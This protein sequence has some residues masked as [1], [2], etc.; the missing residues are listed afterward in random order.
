MRYDMETTLTPKQDEAWEYLHDDTSTE[1]FLWWWAWWGKTWLWCLWLLEQCVKYPWIRVLLWRAVL[2]SLKESTVLSFTD[3]LKAYWFKKDVHYK[4]TIEWTIRFL[5]NWSEI[6][7]KDL[8]QYP[9]DKDFDSLWSTEFTMAFIDEASQIT[10]KAKN[11]VTSRLRYKLNEYWLTPK[12]LICSNPTK[13]WL[14]KDFYLPRKDWT[15]QPH[16][17][18]VLSLA[19]DNPHLPPEY[20]KN[21]ERLDEVSKQRLLYWNWE[22]DSSPWKMFAYDDI[23]WMFSN[24]VEQ[25]NE[26]YM[27]VDVARKWNDK[28]VIW[29]WNWLDLVNV[30]KEDKSN[31]NELIQTIDNLSKSL[32]ISRRNITIDEDWVWGGVVD[33]LPWVVWFVN[34]STALVKKWEI[35]NYNNLKTQCTFE[36]ARLVKDKKV[37]ISHRIYEKE[38]SEELEQIMQI[39]ID[40]DTRLRLLWKDKIKESLW[41]SPDF[42]DMLVMRMIFEVKPKKTVFFGAV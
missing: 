27:S 20:I 21:L 38:I 3:L 35:N 29:M 13:G 33:W 15:L 10:E 12:L 42:S 19:S 8:Y 31:L 36:L 22:Y 18:F 11:I 32:W 2:K 4:I 5:T 14:Y 1:V 9:S 6:F 34:N 24:K 17:K 37:R 23:I 40:K 26:K 41:R 16:R 28:T 25:N 39:D 7:L 30:I